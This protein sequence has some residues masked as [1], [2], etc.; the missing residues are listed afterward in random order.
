VKVL[1]TLREVSMEILI[2]GAML[3]MVVLIWTV[4]LVY[5]YTAPFVRK[6]D[7]RGR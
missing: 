3:G 4:A 7:D 1:R 6:A 2:G 5:P